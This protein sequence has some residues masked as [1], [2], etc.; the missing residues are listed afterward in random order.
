MIR[1]EL[2]PA[3]KDNYIFL[4][5]DGTSALVVDPADP[6]V[7]L[8]GL[9]ER[10]LE[11]LTIL[12]THHHPDHVGGNRI[13]KAQT[14]CT[15]Y[16]PANDADRIPAMDVGL[17]DGEQFE[18][19]G[20]MFTYLEV[21][22]HTTGHGAYMAPG[23][24]SAFVGDTLFALGCGRMFE[25]NPPMFW[26]SLR[27]LRDLPPDTLIYC[28]HEYT[29]A[30]ARFALSVDPDNKALKS[31]IARF[32]ALRAEDTP[33][34]PVRLSEEIA[35]NPFLR[36]DDPDLQKILG[37]EGQAPSDVFAQLRA[38]KDHF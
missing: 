7:V 16:G 29:L 32:E 3:L 14:G 33:T 5:H 22:G 6:K 36:A 15:I 18:A 23:L 8:D 30:N 10:G 31:R 34:I 38:Q 27:K 35:T 1:T 4:I 20:Q 19:L 24:Q 11:L 17:S 25:G 26:N 13:L 9:K 28:T 21:P 12:N 2:L 37:L